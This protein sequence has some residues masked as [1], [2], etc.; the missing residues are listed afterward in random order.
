MS[1]GGLTAQQLL[2]ALGAMAKLPASACP[3]LARSLCAAAAAAAPTLTANRLGIAAWALTRP[4]VHA[5]LTAAE[6]DAWHAALRA[7][8]LQVRWR[9]PGLV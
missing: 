4:A 7:R 1:E 3:P 9:T 6:L 8:T 5:R 2:Y